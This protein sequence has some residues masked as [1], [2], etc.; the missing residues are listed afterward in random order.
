M[1]ST[2]QFFVIEE[3][4]KVALLIQGG[5]WPSICD[6]AQDPSFDLAPGNAAK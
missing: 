4:K 6:G 2:E 5:K 1:I 3:K